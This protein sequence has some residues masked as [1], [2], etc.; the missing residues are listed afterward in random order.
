MGIVYCGLRFF[1]LLTL[2]TALCFHTI[3]WQLPKQESE[4][5]LPCRTVEKLPF[6]L[7]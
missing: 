1:I 3:A 5:N 6:F 7:L 4:L 2:I